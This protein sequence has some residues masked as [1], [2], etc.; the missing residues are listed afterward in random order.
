MSQSS[1]AGLH[2]VRGLCG[3][4][5]WGCSAG[6]DFAGFAGGVLVRSGTLWVLRAGR[7]VWLWLWKFIWSMTMIKEDVL[8]RICYTE[9]VY[10]RIRKKL[11]VDLSNDAIEKM[12]DE[13]IEETDVR[14][15]QKIGKNIYITNAD[16]N[17]RLTI[18]S[19]T[20][21]MITADRLKK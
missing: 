19:Y 9:L 11:G 7:L 15:F 16:R 21:R 6:G 8:G 2:C 5:G 13:I 18:N 12:I 1:R 10:G 3:F 20:N 17:V 4:C 14:L